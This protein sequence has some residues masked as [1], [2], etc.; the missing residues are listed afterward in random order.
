MKQWTF[1]HRKFAHDIYVYYQEWDCYIL[2]IF[3]VSQARL[4]FPDFST[5]YFPVRV[6]EIRCI[7]SK[8]HQL[9]ELKEAIGDK[10]WLQS[11]QDD[12]CDQ[13]VYAKAGKLDSEGLT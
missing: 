2:E 3:H 6:L 1:K 8:S 10:K 5:R 4:V 11:A 9:D 12:L 13:R 7:L